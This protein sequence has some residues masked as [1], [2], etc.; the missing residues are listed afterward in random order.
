M[1]K[2]RLL[3]TLVQQKQREAEWADWDFVVEIDQQADDPQPAIRAGYWGW[4]EIDWGDGQGARRYSTLNNA[5]GSIRYDGTLTPGTYQ[6]KLRVNPNTTNASR[7]V[8]FG[9]DAAASGAGLYLRNTYCPQLKRVLK[10]DMSHQRTMT[11]MFCKCYRLEEVCKFTNTSDIISAYSA[12]LC[13]TSLRGTVAFDSLENC[14]SMVFVFWNTPKLEKVLLGPL[15][16]ATSI[17]DCFNKCGASEI[18]LSDLSSCTNASSAFYFAQNLKK[19]IIPGGLPEATTIANF[20]NGCTELE[21]VDIGTEVPNA[22]ACNAAFYRCEK[23]KNLHGLKSFPKMNNAMQIFAYCQALEEIELETG[24]SCT[25]MASA[26]FNCLNLKKL[27]INGGF[28]EVASMQ[29]FA[30]HDTKLDQI[31]VNGK[32]CVFPDLPKLTSISYAFNETA[33]TSLVMGDM[34]LL[35]SM[36][37]AC[38]LCYALE[39]VEIG[40]IGDWNEETQSYS[41][42]CNA[43]SCCNYDF[44]LK[45]FKIGNNNI[46]DIGS[47]FYGCQELEE[48]EL[49]ERGYKSPSTADDDGL[50]W[51]GSA[52]TYCNSLRKVK[53]CLKLRPQGPS[54]ATGWSS[55]FSCCGMLEELPDIFPANGFAKTFTVKNANLANIFQ[56]CFSI[57]GTVPE[58]LWDEDDPRHFKGTGSTG[59]A[60]AFCFG[61]SNYDDIPRAWKGNLEL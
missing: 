47:F 24:E 20:A 4:V 59:N 55:M 21:E 29:A 60:F 50:R 30:H 48:V 1:R 17:Q 2:T 6:L 13:C 58:W 35:T 8:K 7:Y 37:Y 51:T 25:T 32:N 49:G 27:T 18:I 26:F 38:Q 22:S 42:S 3:Q 11:Y 10:A 40:D 45:R 16:K 23:L 19:I 44:K 61:L 28:D 43:T 36:D 33:I 54:T 53:G 39:E 9:P 5:S 56:N 15:P 41:N 31:I 52:F 57:K 12:F 46:Y 14:T 34:P